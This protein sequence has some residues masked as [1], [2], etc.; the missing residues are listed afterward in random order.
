MLVGSGGHLHP[1]GLLRRP[2]PDPRRRQSAA[3]DSAAATSVEG[4][5]AHL[6]RSDAN[7]WEPAGAVSWDVAMTVTAPRLA[8]RTVKKGDVLSIQ[9]TY[10]MSRGLVVRVDGHHE[11]LDGRRRR[12]QR[13]VR[14]QGRRPGSGHP[15][16]PARERQPRRHRRA[17]SA[18]T[19]SPCRPSPRTATV[20]IFDFVYCAG[21][22]G[23]HQTVP[24]VKAGPDAHVHQ[25]RRQ[26]AATACGTR[27]P[28]ARLRATARPGSPTHWPTPTSSFDSGELGTGGPPTADRVTWS[29]PT[30]LPD[31]H[32]HLLLPHPPVHARARSRSRPDRGQRG[33]ISTPGLSIARGSSSALAARSAEAN[34]RGAAGR[35]RAGGRARRRGGG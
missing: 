7:Y 22:H 20:N 8:G 33:S 12:R 1:G 9:T 31:G 3:P 32:L 18:P 6:F 23:E 29:T 24:T 13:S 35:T 21:R 19:R 30:D 11:R 15:R 10:D 4:D 5:T 14:G 2:L 16:P 34:T 17:S 25:Q 27:S 26:D 28:R